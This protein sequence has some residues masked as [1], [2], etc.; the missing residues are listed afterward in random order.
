M[1]EAEKLELARLALEW[2]KRA[3]YNLTIQ[4]EDNP[5]WRGYALARK[6]DAEELE[7]LLTRLGA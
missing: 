1:D 5:W 2:R 7:T 6:E 3:A 4:G